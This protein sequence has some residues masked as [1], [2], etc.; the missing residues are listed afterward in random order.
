MH[1]IQAKYEISRISEE[2]AAFSQYEEGL[3]ER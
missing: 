2:L 3:L 1:I